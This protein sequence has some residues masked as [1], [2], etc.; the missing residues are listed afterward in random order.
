M[1]T[2]AELGAG[3]PGRTT[4]RQ[5]QSRGESWCASRS[6]VGDCSRQAQKAEAGLIVAGSD[7]SRGSVQEV[8]QALR[9]AVLPELGQLSPADYELAAAAAT[10]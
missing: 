2:G 7:V 10:S 9:R 8:A 3:S 4:W 5:L 1:T 6:K